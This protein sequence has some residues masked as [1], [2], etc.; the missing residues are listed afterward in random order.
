[1]T[2]IALVTGAGSGIGRA[3]AQLLADRG[4][5]VITTYH[6]NPA[7]HV[8][9]PLDVSDTATFPAF[10]DRVRDALQEHW[11][12]EDLDFLVNNAG[13]GG[14]SPFDATSDDAYERYHR[15]LLKGPF[16]LTQT[17]LPLI[18]E[19]I[20]NVSSSSTR[21]GVTTPGYAAYAAM[22]GGVDMLT[23]Y[24]AK[25]LAPIRVN[26]V[27]PGPTRTNLGDNGF[28]RYPEAIPP[29]I[30]ET[31]LNRLGES[32]DVGKAI[33]ALLSDDLAWITGE[34]IEVS[35]GFKL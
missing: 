5:G 19:G 15:T 29:I 2:K 27:S 34:V 21:P 16:F 11:G 24:L 17:L 13:I 4:F 1:M 25:E 35:G 22:K 31:T 7:D 8:G 26:A 9:L 20:V 12:R 30:A 10:A 3:T 32:E 28:E 23:P 14:P 33:A 18:R 6:R